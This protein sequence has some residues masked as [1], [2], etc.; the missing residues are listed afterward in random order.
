MAMLNI[1][2]K[3]VLTGLGLRVRSFLLFIGLQSLITFIV[4]SLVDPYTSVATET[5]IRGIGVGVLWGFGSP[6]ILWSLSREEV[7]RITP[8]S[9]SHPLLA[10]I[11]AVIFLGESLSVMESVAAALAIGGVLLAALKLSGTGDRI[12]I[13]STVGI[14]LVAVAVVAVAQTL[15]KT[16]TDDLSFW[17]ALGLRS[18]GMAFV[19]IPMNMRPDIASELIRFARGRKQLAALAID[20]GFATVAMSLITFAIANGPLSLTS[21]IVGTTPLIVFFLSVLLSWKTPL[22]LEETLTTGVVTQKLVAAALVV[23]GLVMI[24]LV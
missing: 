6:V 4:I 24:A 7:S 2:D 9:Q 8:I 10:V 21:A 19:L 3:I 20:V 12:T 16:V 14:L 18:A 17:Q 11:F 13:S 22:P 5:W 1:A 15:L 23:S